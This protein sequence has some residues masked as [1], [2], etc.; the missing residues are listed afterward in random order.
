MKTGIADTGTPNKSEIYAMVKVFM[1]ESVRTALDR[2]E[3]GHGLVDR[4][5]RH[6]AM[7]QHVVDPRGC[8]ADMEK[9]LTV[10]ITDGEYPE[11]P[12]RLAVEAAL[13]IQKVEAVAFDTDQIVEHVCYEAGEV[14]HERYCFCDDWDRNVK[15][16]A[17]FEPE[18]PVQE[19]IK[20][21]IA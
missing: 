16:F 5:M 20:D 9:L 15:I 17:D 8:G 1:R 10:A 6:E 13:E 3:H 11:I 7:M 19:I 2:C 14:R 12:G 4:N 21:A 18:T